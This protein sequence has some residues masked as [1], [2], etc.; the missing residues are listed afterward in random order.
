[1]LFEKQNIEIPVSFVIEH[2]DFYAYDPSVDYSIEDNFKYLKE[3]LLQVIH[4]PTQL[5]ID[6]GWYGSKTENKGE[7]V[8][9]IISNNYWDV[10][11][12]KLLAVSQ[13]DILETLK[14]TL[15]ALHLGVLD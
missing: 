12:S 14:K 9:Q 10:P 3:D 8:L 1:M 13:V 7:F 6:L 5:I 11:V 2:N 15:Q 4:I